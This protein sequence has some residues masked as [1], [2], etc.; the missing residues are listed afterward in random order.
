MTFIGIV[1]ISILYPQ[2]QPCFC[3]QECYPP[4]AMQEGPHFAEWGEMQQ[5]GGVSMASVPISMNNEVVASLT[6]ASSI[7]AAFDE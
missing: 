4:I 7:P 2:F 6:L 1:R 5:Q 3:T